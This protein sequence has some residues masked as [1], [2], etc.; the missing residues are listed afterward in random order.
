MTKV[1]PREIAHSHP[2]MTRQHQ[3][4]VQATLASG[5]LARGDIA[6]KFAQAVCPYNGCAGGLAFSSG[7]ASLVFNLKACRRTCDD[8][9]LELSGKASKK[10][11]G[12]ISGASY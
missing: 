8:L 9:S 6:E 10:L 11:F 5:M 1:K 7:M 4:D 3:E 2:W 12:E